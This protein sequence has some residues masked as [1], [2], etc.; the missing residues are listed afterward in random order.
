MCISHSVMRASDISVLFLFTMAQK[1][2]SWLLTTHAIIDGALGG[3]FK[4]V[5][6]TPKTVREMTQLP[7]NIKGWAHKQI[8]E[9]QMNTQKTHSAQPGCMNW[10]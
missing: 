8:K 7:G 4:L 1:G 9:T 5:M 6:L 3:S 10:S 2:W